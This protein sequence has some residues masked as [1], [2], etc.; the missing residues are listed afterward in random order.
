MLTIR[1][2]NY[3]GNCCSVA[4]RP[5]IGRLLLNWIV[6]GYYLLEKDGLK[7]PQSVV[8]ATNSYAHDSDKITQF[9]EDVLIADGACEVRTA[10]VYERYKR[11]CSDNGCFFENS[12]NFN[13]ELR[14][15]GRVERKRPQGGGEKTTMLIG[16]RLKDV[17]IDFLGG[18]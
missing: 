14:K 15:F 5:V 12:R 11:W 9:A 13:Q 7:P 10:I 17:I 18:N 8:D 4:T 3:E 6:E 16:F 2:Y 1:Y